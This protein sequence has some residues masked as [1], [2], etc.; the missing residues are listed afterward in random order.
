MGLSVWQEQLKNLGTFY[1]PQNNRLRWPSIFTLPDWMASWWRVFGAGYEEQ[2]LIVQENDEI[3]GIAPLKLK[4]GVTSF[5]GDNSVCDY[6]DFIVVPGKEGTFSRAFLDYLIGHGV[7]SMV[8]ETLRPE[9]IAGHEVLEA[10]QRF[11]KSTTSLQ[12]DV[13]FEMELPATWEGYLDSLA[14]KQRRE[15]ERKMRQIETVAEVHSHVFRNAEVGETE[16]ATFFQM[17]GDSRR[18][19]AQFLTTGTR[20]FFKNIVDATSAYGILRLAYLK[21]GKASVAAIL[22]F[23]YDD[24]IYLYNSGYLP[25][26]ADMSVGLVSKLLC[27]KNAIMAHCVSTFDFLKGSEAYKTHL[28][29]HEVGLSRCVIDLQ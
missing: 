1:S 7:K 29:S 17:M 16:L 9:S 18:D 3:I 12:I 21:V 4:D 26:Y 27:I 2:V 13:S 25:Q 28:G 14:A 22:Y 10:A 6:L 8:L 24:R 5:I 19:K 11:G 23:E 15:I 20:D